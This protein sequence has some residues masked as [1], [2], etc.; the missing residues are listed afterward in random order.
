MRGYSAQILDYTVVAS[1]QP[2]IASAFNRL[3][4]QVHIPS[5]EILCWLLS[6]LFYVELDW[7]KLYSYQHLPSCIRKYHEYFWSLCYRVRPSNWYPFCAMTDPPYSQAGLIIFTIG[8]ALSTA[9]QSMPML[10]VGRG[11]SGVGA[12]ALLTVR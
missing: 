11:I 5:P 2:Q 6:P 9:A 8:S 3:D 12:A 4:I 10:L 7:N 1:A